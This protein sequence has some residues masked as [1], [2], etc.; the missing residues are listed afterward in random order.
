MKDWIKDHIELFSIAAMIFSGFLWMNGKFSDVDKQ[1]AEVRLE[2]ATIRQEV[3]ILRTV[4]VMKNIMP[5][6]LAWQENMVK[7]EK[8]IWRDE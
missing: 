3:A 7:Q 4:L 6:E 8:G 1:F 2:I 5:C